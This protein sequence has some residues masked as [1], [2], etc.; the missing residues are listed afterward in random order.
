[1]WRGA[2]RGGREDARRRHAA[3]D[4]L[5]EVTRADEPEPEHLRR[6]GR[7]R[8]HGL[9]RRRHCE[10][11]EEEE[12]EE[13]AEASRK[14]GERGLGEGECGAPSS[15]KRD[16]ELELR[17]KQK[18][19]EWHSKAREETLKEIAKEMAKY[20]NED[21]SDTPGVKAR[22]DWEYR[23]SAI[24]G[25]YDTISPI[26]PMRYTH[27][28]DDPMPRHIS[29]R[30]TLQ[31]ISVKI[32][33]IRGGLQWPINVFGLIAARDTIDRNRIMIFNRTRDNCQTITKED[34]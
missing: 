2:D 8:R 20:P 14:K 1:M 31:I 21:W 25:P 12:E 3:G 33:G 24:F 18:A 27:R 15:K 7:G 10:G 9:R 5:R 29:V 28:K 16:P 6:R 23:W 32:K 26:P 30:H 17:M 19:A 11:S 34:R 13:E 4:A 22:E